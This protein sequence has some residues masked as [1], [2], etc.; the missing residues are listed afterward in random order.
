MKSLVLVSSVSLNPGNSG[1][2]HSYT[3]PELTSSDS[4]C[5]IMSI[6]AKTLPNDITQ[7]GCDAAGLNVK[8]RTVSIPI[9]KP[10][11]SANIVYEV[12]MSGG[13]KI[14]VTVPVNVACNSVTIE[15]PA[16]P[17][18]YEVLTG[19]GTAVMSLDD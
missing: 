3:L 4:A 7:T 14:D 11:S 19:S 18:T 2:M 10:F 15:G 1:T 6:K 12:T 5:P 9:D 8:C 17:L 16:E 13:K